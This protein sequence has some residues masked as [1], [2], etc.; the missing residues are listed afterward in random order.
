MLFRST[1][2]DTD[3]DTD[4]DTDT[5][6]SIT[7]FDDV[8][9]IYVDYCGDCHESWG[10][11]GD[12]DRVWDT[13]VNQGEDGQPFVI[14]GDAE[15]SW[16]YDKVAHDS[17]ADG[18]ARMPIATTLVE[19]DDLALIEEWI[20]AGAQDDAMWQ[21][22]FWSN[23][24]DRHCHNCHGEWG[25]NADTVLDSLLT[26][27]E[28]GY[29]LVDPGVPENSLF[30]LKVSSDTPPTGDRMPIRYDYLSDEQVAV[31]GAWI[32]AGAAND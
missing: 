32:D 23:W 5:D 4:T 22:V 11:D 21:Q 7:Y 13:L 16:L 8:F 9:P 2:T 10:G 25:Q 15:G 1:D 17:P 24:M 12:P 26:V 14:P 28:D 29:P 31:I 27:E 30:Y 19:G 18:K 20:T 3:A 6:T